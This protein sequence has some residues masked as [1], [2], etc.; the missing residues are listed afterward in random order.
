MRTPEFLLGLLL[1]IDILFTFY[2]RRK[3]KRNFERMDLTLNTMALLVTK[4][5][6]SNKQLNTRII[7]LEKARGIDLIAIQ[8]LEEVQLRVAEIEQ[9]VW[10]R[11]LN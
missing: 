5:A 3:I 9:V 10:E 6:E 2:D 4:L 1:S 8:R 7:D 11:E